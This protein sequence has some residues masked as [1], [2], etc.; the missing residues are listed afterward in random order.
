ML[1]VDLQ[2]LRKLNLLR[3]QELWGVNIPANFA[4]NDTEYQTALKLVT[5]QMIADVARMSG[6]APRAE[7]QAAANASA[8]P[9]MSPEARRNIIVSLKSALN[10]QNSLYSD[11]DA[12]TREPLRNYL[13]RANSSRLFDKIVEQA[14]KD[15]PQYGGSQSSRQPTAQ[16]AAEELARRRRGGNQ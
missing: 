16:E 8:I 3:L 12:T 5:Q 13:N 15:T 14:E 10:Y 6:N 11:Y 7:L 9:S 1:V 2:R 4:N